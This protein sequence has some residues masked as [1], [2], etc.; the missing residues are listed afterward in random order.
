MNMRR[1]FEKRFKRTKRFISVMT[2][3]TFALA[4][5]GIC[6]MGYALYRVSVM[7]GIF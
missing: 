3:I 6:L 2:V 4:I 5:F 7:L 1:D